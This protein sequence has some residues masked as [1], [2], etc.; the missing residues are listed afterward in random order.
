VNPRLQG[1]HPYPF[2]RL[3][4]LFEGK[5]P[6]AD[7][8]PINLGIGEPQHATPTLITEALQQNMH[9]LGKYPPTAGSPEL[10]GAISG[11]IGRRYGIPEPDPAREVI[12]VAGTREALF[13]FA[14]ALLDSADRPAVLLPNPFYQIYEGAATMAG[15]EPIYVPTPRERDYLPD[16]S[17]VP[18]EVWPR[19]RLAYVCSPGNP[20]GA[21]MEDEQ[22]AELFEL[23]DR[24]GFVIAADECYSEIYNG[25][26]PTGALQASHRI[27]RGN[28]RIV[29]FNSLS[30]RSSAPGLRSGFVAGDASILEPYLLY[31]TYHGAAP[32]ALTQAASVPAWNDETHVEQNR[33]KYQAKFVRVME[34][35]PDAPIPAGGFFLW[36]PCDDDEQLA[37]DLYTQ[38]GLTVLPGQYLARDVDGRNPGRGHLRV[39]LVPEVEVCTEALCR[40]RDLLKQN[41]G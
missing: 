1:L 40:L 11:W 39:A 21:V 25:A 27:G 38:A 30:K 3:R 18:P 34:I 20:A 41:H 37:A 29:A 7:L 4:R 28:E 24:Y 23:A 32:S 16:W 13:A 35:L 15:A 22:W 9:L 6:P 5:N 26:P 33:A 36:L 31:R 17:A 2:E 19:V 10:R 8:K 14:Q 12:P